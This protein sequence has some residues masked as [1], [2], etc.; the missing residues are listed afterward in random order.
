MYYYVCLFTF[1]SCAHSLNLSWFTHIL[2]FC[3]NNWEMHFSQEFC[4]HELYEIKEAEQLQVQ[5]NQLYF[6]WKYSDYNYRNI[7]CNWLCLYCTIIM[8]TV[9]VIIVPFTSPV[10]DFDYVV[11]MITIYTQEHNDYW[12]LNWPQLHSYQL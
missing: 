7:A 10:I 6:T 3:R 12:R 9:T 5:G 2:T 4:N 1:W 11:I 8:I